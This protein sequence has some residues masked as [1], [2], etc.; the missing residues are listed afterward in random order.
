M[1]NIASLNHIVYTIKVKVADFIQDFLGN[2]GCHR[3]LAYDSPYPST[4]YTLDLRSD[5]LQAKH[6]YLD[7]FNTEWS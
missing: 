5:T 2:R 7:V 6:G 3:P 4:H 1:Q